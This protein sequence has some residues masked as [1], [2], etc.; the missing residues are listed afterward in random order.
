MAGLIPAIHV[1]AARSVKDVDAW[2][3]PGHGELDGIALAKTLNERQ[4]ADPGG[5]YSAQTHGQAQR[6]G[7]HRCL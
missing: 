5:D 4:Y 6:L 7:L 1:V 3:K 2:D